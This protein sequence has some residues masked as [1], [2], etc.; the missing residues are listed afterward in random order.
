MAKKACSNGGDQ[1]S[2][3]LLLLSLSLLLPS[4]APSAWAAELEG[5]TA[6]TGTG[7]GWRIVAG[8]SGAVT[9]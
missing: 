9:S 4:E 7:S 3:N 5:W 8:G 2:G 6:A 1:S